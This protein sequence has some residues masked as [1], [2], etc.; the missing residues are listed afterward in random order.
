MGASVIRSWTII[1]LTT[2]N[3]T[4]SQLARTT[5]FLQPPDRTCSIDSNSTPH[6]SAV[7]ELHMPISE[8]S[9]IFPFQYYFLSTIP[10]LAPAILGSLFV[11][12]VPQ[13]ITP[14]ILGWCQP[15][16]HNIKTCHHGWSYSS[17]SNRMLGTFC[18]GELIF[19]YALCFLYNI[20]QLLQINT[21]LLMLH[22]NG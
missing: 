16:R 8:P 4:S 14:L 5:T 9:H 15:V 18:R 12:L 2:Q 20:C 10:L 17:L 7:S 22:R 3:P 19:N 6:K 21:I 11:F 13:V 1:C